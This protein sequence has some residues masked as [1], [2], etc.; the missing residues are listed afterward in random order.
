MIYSSKMY[1]CRC[2]NC[3]SDYEMRPYGNDGW[4]IKVLYDAE[5]LMASDVDDSD[6][7]TED[8]KH[9]CPECFKGFDA[10][11]K[12]VLRDLNKKE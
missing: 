1:A 10:E 9:Y 5:S 12:L 8:D 3:G 6:W 11:D 2:D 4:G 7:H